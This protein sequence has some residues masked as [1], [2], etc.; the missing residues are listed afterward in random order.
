MGMEEEKRE[1]QH[2]ISIQKQISG[3]VGTSKA[4]PKK[5]VVSIGKESNDNDFG[6]GIE[7]EKAKWGGEETDEDSDHQ[8]D[9]LSQQENMKFEDNPVEIGFD[10]LKDVEAE[11]KNDTENSAQEDEKP[12]KTN[13]STE[14]T[15]TQIG[16][17]EQPNTGL[18][19][20]INTGISYKK[21]LEDS[22][23]K[24]RTD[25][26]P[27]TENADEM[28][29]IHKELIN[30]F[31]DKSNQS[32]NTYIT[33]NDFKHIFLIGDIHSD[34]NSLMEILFLPDGPMDKI[35]DSLIVFLG[36]YFDR[37]YAPLH[38]FELV[39][40]LKI[41]Y[42]D[43]I[44]LLKGNHD[45]FKMDSNDR[46]TSSVKDHP[47]LFVN[48]LYYIHRQ[49]PERVARY[50]SI[51]D[52]MQWYA[53]LDFGGLK[54]FAVHGGPTRPNLRTENYYQYEIGE[55]DNSEH[56]DIIGD[57]LSLPESM[58]WGDPV[59]NAHLRVNSEVRFEFNKTHFVHFMKKMDCDLLVRGHQT[60][61]EGY[62]AHFDNRCLTIFSSGKGKDDNSTVYSGYKDITKDIIRVD[63]KSK[64]VYVLD[65]ME[66]RFEAAISF[67]EIKAARKNHEINVK[68]Y[69]PPHISILNNNPSGTSVFRLL[70]LEIHDL[71]N[72][73]KLFAQASQLQKGIMYNYEN[74]RGFF[75]GIPLNI[76]LRIL[77]SADEKTITLRN[78]SSEDIDIFV[79]NHILPV[80]SQCFLNQ[81]STIL[82]NEQAALR[83][84]LKTTN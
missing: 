70:S 49:N 12:F 27:G 48:Y 28:W 62:M 35:K 6:K 77:Y 33:A 30:A 73:N 38:V 32:R 40:R 37:G 24:D 53:N 74:L 29:D 44:V 7:Q 34:F 25:I 8:D 60:S 45:I 39:L 13:D 67:D 26:F 50:L 59:D 75:Y 4:E 46:Y 71:M 16:L 10:R 55:L 66:N 57:K 19:D 83:I 3:I 18:Q 84:G 52:N 17:K 47:D 61:K 65:L 9:S 1:N 42:P 63:T 72:G 58:T 20:D 21:L 23:V 2:F 56:K 14:E 15:V 76:R 5:N 68:N 22:I 11:P 64:M 78:D 54:I 81:D 80:G 51:F 31:I 69:E 36:D 79:D 41:D 43:H 82:I